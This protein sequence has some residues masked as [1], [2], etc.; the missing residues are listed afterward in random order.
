[1]GLD[2]TI[3][4]WWQ[5]ILESQL[6]FMTRRNITGH[7]RCSQAVIQVLRT[8]ISSLTVDVAREFILNLWNLIIFSGVREISD[9]IRHVHTLITYLQSIFQNWSPIRILGFIVSR[10]CVRL[11]GEATR[12]FPSIGSIPTFP[13]IMKL[14][15]IILA[16]RDLCLNI[17]LWVIN[18]P[19]RVVMVLV[20]RRTIP[21][22]SWSSHLLS[23]LVRCV[24]IRL[25]IHSYTIHV[26][27]LSLDGHGTN[28]L[29]HL[30]RTHLLALLDSTIA[31]IH[32]INVV[33]TTFSHLL[34]LRL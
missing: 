12:S 23:V 22:I 19:I 10:D 24:L 33:V 31:V 7:A 25:L 16:C 3:V 6:P 30:V 21:L 18:C 5:L 8:L 13:Q 2:A 4:P 32:L 28:G 29:G 14:S 11:R 15:I 27:G 17:S 9:S 20:I 26:L 34:I 1:M